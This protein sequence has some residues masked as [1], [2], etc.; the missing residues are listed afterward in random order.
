M[1]F[2]SKNG[3]E[4]EL[5]YKEPEPHPFVRPEIIERHRY[6]SITPSGN[7]Y[8]LLPS[9]I[10]VTDLPEFLEGGGPGIVPE[11]IRQ[12][13]AKPGRRFSL[14]HHYYV[15]PD[16]RVFAGQDPEY[17]GFLA[18]E[19]I[20]DALLIAVLG[21]F[22]GPHRFSP[23]GAGTFTGAAVCVAV[24]RTIARSRCNR[25]RQR[26][27]ILSWANSERTLPIG[28]GPTQTLR[29]NVERTIALR[30]EDEGG[31]FFSDSFEREKKRIVPTPSTPSRNRCLASGKLAPGG[32]NRRMMHVKN[33]FE[34]RS[35]TFS[36]EF[37][38]PRN[39]A[40]AES[41]YTTISQLEELKPSFVSVTYGAGG[42]TRELT[43]DLVVRIKNSTTL[44]R[45]SPSHLRSPHRGGDPCHSRAL[46]EGECGDDSG[47]RRRSSKNLPGYDR[48]KDDFRFATDLVRFIR[49]FNESGA[50][51]NPRGF[52]IGVAGYPEGHQET[53]NRLK[54]MDFL[55]AK[56]DAGADYICTQLF[57]D[58][59]DFYDFRDRC[60][61]AGIHVPVIAGIMPVTSEKGMARMAELA[62]G[63]RFP[64]SLFR[65]VKR[66][67]GDPEAIEES[68]F[69]GL[70]SSAGTSWT[71]TF[72]ASTSTL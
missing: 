8:G 58:N 1:P 44:E 24:S 49:K 65:A 11:K 40:A 51:P 26:G 10:G 21:D 25:S 14:P 2:L 17:C 15:A 52:G 34:T 67:G 46:R 23:S 22:D 38:P 57:F 55:K 31:G 41:L 27:S 50:H 60:E 69:T 7:L 19:R 53:P 48:S 37:F 9:R 33:I 6:L 13:G 68:E 54:E 62:A 56:V 72:G 16:G 20:K 32:Q 4:G 63:A 30:E 5:A 18:N 39:Q 61:L 71:T 47:A 66:C 42:S 12:A 36:F 3:D 59:R 35:T 64:A 29:K 43:H 28:S 70:P 45:D